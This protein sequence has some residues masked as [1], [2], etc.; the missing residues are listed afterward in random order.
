MQTHNVCFQ[1]YLVANNIAHVHHSILS[2]PE[3]LG[4]SEPT[5]AESK[6]RMQSSSTGS[7][8]FDNTVANMGESQGGEQ[9][10]SKQSEKIPLW[11]ITRR[12]LTES[13]DEE[14]GPT[15]PRST[16]SSETSNEQL[17][18]LVAV[19]TKDMENI[20]YKLFECVP[21]K[22]ETISYYIT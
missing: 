7:G 21:Q 12:S 5:D 13:K 10:G 20:L 8:S 14:E 16:Y 6:A 11:A 2:I 18:S 19:A 9:S 1:V 4:F 3:E 17:Q 22:V 15:A